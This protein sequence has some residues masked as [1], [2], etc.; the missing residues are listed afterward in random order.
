MREEMR[1]S[2]WIEAVDI[3]GREQRRED[4]ER[5]ILGGRADKDDVAGFDVGKKGVLLGFIEAVNLIHEDDGA[6]AGAGF[7]FGDGH[8]FLDFLY[9]GENGAEGNKF[10]TG[11][12]HD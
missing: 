5:G 4:L 9:A 7:V 12:A 10:G 11:Q 2:E 8:N 6:M 1:S 3:G